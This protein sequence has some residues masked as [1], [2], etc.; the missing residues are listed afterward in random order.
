[1]TDSIKTTLCLRK[2]SPRVRMDID[3][4]LCNVVTP[5]GALLERYT[6]PSHQRS[7][8][9]GTKTK[10]IVRCAA[11]V[12]DPGLGDVPESIE[13][14]LHLPNAL[15]GHNLEHG[16]SVFAAGVAA[17]ELQRIW[18]AGFGLPREELDL[19]TPDD[20]TLRGVTIT[21]HHLM[22]DHE[23]AKDLVDAVLATGTALGIC[24]YYGSSNLTVYLNCGTFKLV[25]YIKTDLSHCAFPSDAPVER[26]IGSAGSIVRIEAVLGERFLKKYHRT[27]LRSWENAYEKGL[28]ERIYNLTVRKLLRLDD[29]LRHKEPRAEVYERLTPT[30]ERLL[31]GY[32]AGHDPRKF[33]NVVESRSPGKRFSELRKSILAKA[34]TDI[35]IPWDKHVQLRCFEL[36]VPLRY[37][38]DHHPD[39]EHAPW[40]FC[41][42]NWPALLQK[43]R[44][45]Y[46]ETL[47]GVAKRKAATHPPGHVVAL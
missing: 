31:R 36:E 46:E 5:W 13:S 25:F 24:E 12:N 9:S 10:W 4:R 47:T 41:E 42:E 33:K 29:G 32:I 28:Y 18:M 20:I 2:L 14:Q 34:N 15:T 7:A 11:D 38:G 8:M 43:L 19:L 45:K 1:M 3:A 30:E 21:F 35:D 23:T 22:A 37:P 40:C 44:D 39:G 26:L 6:K 16:T 17:L 27:A